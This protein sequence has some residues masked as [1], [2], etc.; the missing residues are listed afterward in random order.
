MAERMVKR[1]K[2]KRPIKT[3]LRFIGSFERHNIETGRMIMN[4]SEDMLKTI[5]IL[6]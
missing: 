2:E 3:N 6:E 1:P 5:W 4:R